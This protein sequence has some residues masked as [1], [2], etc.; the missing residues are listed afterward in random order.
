MVF[1]RV[2]ENWSRTYGLVNQR[3]WVPNGGPKDSHYHFSYPPPKQI[4]LKSREE[5]KQMQY[6]KAM[7]MQ[8]GKAIP[9]GYDRPLEA[10]VTPYWPHPYQNHTCKNSKITISSPYGRY[11]RD[12]W[13][14]ILM[15]ER[16]YD[17]IYAKVGSRWILMGFIGAQHWVRVGFWVETFDPSWVMRKSSSGHGAVKEVFFTEILSRSTFYLRRC[18]FIGQTYIRDC[19]DLLRKCLVEDIDVTLRWIPAHE[20]VPGNEAADRAAKHIAL[21]GAQRQFVPEVTNGWIILTAAAKQRIQQST[22]DTWEKLWDKQKAGK[23]TKK[24]VTQ[25]SKRTLQ[26]WTFLWKATSSILI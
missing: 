18:V 9:T 10:L 26:Y 20:G 14:V 21:M 15:T 5:N 12:L 3:R 2:P 17:Q 23:P 1:K 16:L 4:D 7:Q 6:G 19:V 22:K 11:A 25:P 8:Y 13:Y 24:L